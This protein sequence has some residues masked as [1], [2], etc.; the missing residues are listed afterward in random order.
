MPHSRR[1]ATGMTPTPTTHRGHVA[2][3]GGWVP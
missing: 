2:S 3:L 1:P